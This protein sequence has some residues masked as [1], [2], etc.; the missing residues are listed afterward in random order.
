MPDM[1]G[2]GTIRDLRASEDPGTRD[3]PVVALT[4]LAM[5]GDHERCVAAGADA[6]LSKPVHLKELVETI[7]R[8]LC[9]S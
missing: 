4:A 9:A 7:A 1:D 8:L 2:I 5:A 3:V 6:Y